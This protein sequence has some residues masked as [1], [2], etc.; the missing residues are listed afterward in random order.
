RI[1][2]RDYLRLDT[3]PLLIHLL[4]GYWMDIPE[5]SERL[6][7]ERVAP[8][9]IISEVISAEPAAQTVPEFAE[10]VGPS[11]SP[12]RASMQRFLRDKRAVISLLIIAVVFLF[13]VF[14]PLFYQH[15]G[16]T[17]HEQIAPG[18]VLTIPPEQYHNSEYEDARRIM[19][20]PDSL[21]W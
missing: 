12:F 7:E 1:S 21:H 17:L 4:G 8:A 5:G 18:Y 13:S 15:V 6:T 10:I 14:F 2:S 19:H 11:L 20:S 16:Q 9:E 3:C